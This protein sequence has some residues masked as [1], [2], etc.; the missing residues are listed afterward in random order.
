MSA[1]GFAAVLTAVATVVIGQMLLKHGMTLVGPIDMGRVKSPIVLVR[2]VISRWQV[3]AGLALYVFSAV[4]WIF[5]LSRVPVSVAY[6]FLALSYI[7]VSTVA[8]IR[9]DEWLTPA[10]WIGI[11]LVVSGVVVVALTS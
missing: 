7:G 9:F 4:V 3:L 5:A 11:V 6:P 10:Q 8:V 1:A 2:D